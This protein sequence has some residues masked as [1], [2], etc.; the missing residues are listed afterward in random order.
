M[1]KEILVYG[2]IIIIIFVGVFSFVIPIRS[3]VEQVEYKVWTTTAPFGIYW[4]N[5]FGSLLFHKTTLEES[6]VVKYIKDDNNLETIMLDAVISKRDDARKRDNNDIIIFTTNVTS[7]MLVKEYTYN[8]V[9]WGFSYYPIL[10]Y[11]LYIPEPD[12]CQEGWYR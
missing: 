8:Y 11:Y 10:R 3:E 5:E 4:R 12:I 1:N 2:I 7:M 6:Y 9:V